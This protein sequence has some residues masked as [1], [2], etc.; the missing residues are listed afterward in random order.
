MVAAEEEILRSNYYTVIDLD[1]VF[2]KALLA[3]SYDGAMPN[4]NDK[5]ILDLKNARHPLL[6][7]EKV[8]SWK[9]YIRKK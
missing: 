3:I 6:K 7:V 5:G 2:A 9:R 4:V 1:K 8:M